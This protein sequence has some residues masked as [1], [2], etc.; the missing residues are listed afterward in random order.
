MTLHQ[1]LKGIYKWN[2]PVIS[3]AAQVG[4]VTI[5]LADT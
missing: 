5:L 4:V 2:I 3:L 1:Q